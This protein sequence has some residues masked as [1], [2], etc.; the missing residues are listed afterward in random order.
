MTSQF[1][2]S[3]VRW[4]IFT[5]CVCAA[6]VLCMLVGVLVFVSSPAL[7]VGAGGEGGCPNE[8]FRQ[9]PSA[10][11]PDCRAYEMASPVYKG[12]YG[13]YG[14]EG[15]AQ[16]GESVAFYSPGAFAGAPAGLAEGVDTVAYM[17]RRSATGWSTVP[18]MPPDALS[19]T[20]IGAA[21]VSPTLD[22]EI[23]PVR[24]DNLEDPSLAQNR[25]EFG[26]HSTETPDLSANWEPFG[27]TMLEATVA[28]SPG[29]LVLEY[30][31]ASVD[32]CHIIFENPYANGSELPLQ[33]LLPAA[34]GAEQP[35]YELDRGCHGEPAE[36]RLVAV[37]NEGKALSPSCSPRLGVE[38]TGA[39]SAFNAVAGG[40]SE[41]FFTTCIDNLQ[42]DRQLFVRLGGGRT[43]E[44]SKP[45]EEA[46]AK[47]PCGGAA[48]RA[49]AVFAGADESGSKVFFTTTAPLS[50]EDKDSGNDLYMASIG[51]P[52]GSG[53]CE[54]TERVVTS[55]VQISH[56][57]VAG[58]PAEVQGV[59][60]VAPDGSRVY[61]V[62]RGVL[63][64][65]A[66]A[67]GTAP[68]KG[69]D[70]LYVYEQDALYP[71]GHIA[72]IGDLC[73][74]SEASGEAEDLRCP[75]KTGVDTALWEATPEAQTA[76]ADG[77]YLVFSTYAQ[78]LPGDADT[79]KDV[80]RY[81]AQ[82]GALARVSTGEAGYDANGNGA[83]N[84]TIAN[85]QSGGAVKQHYEMNSRAVSEDGSRIVFSTNEPLS[86]RAINGLENVYEW[87][88]ASAGSEG[89]VSLLS[90]GSAET[91]V[92]R[93]VISPGGNDVFFVTT[94]GLVPQD[95]DGAP[96]IYDARAD[97]GF[98]P[99][100]APRQQCSS[101]ACQGPLT[102]PAPLL[103]PGSVSQVPGGNFAA[104]A[105]A[106]VATVKSKPRS[107]P[108]KCKRGFV[109]KKGKCV[110]KPKAKKAGESGR[111][112]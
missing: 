35:L 81:D 94:Q 36:L 56:D 86:P 27:G 88:E 84:A 51:C 23:E 41:I 15:V 32:F 75:S 34:K 31:G 80:Y 60:R 17:T 37:N 87:H 96:D 78:L 101:D 20:S 100:A 105:A 18:L 40:G 19:K 33:A 8:A 99:A 43:L 112:K 74:G 76:G 26:L 59:M 77:R 9:G 69:A 91:A 25:M 67:Q 53:E 50:E 39:S 62:A 106:P 85:A 102:N 83:F 4:G 42:G 111:S 54:A 79:A 28:G 49:S 57:P 93:P 108:A 64:K 46:C 63:G 95:T 6:V 97:G 73:S 82:S 10:R 58:E 1:S 21:D 98:P 13:A 66:N 2:R 48:S 14:I 103:V 24:F 16:N 3:G 7:A 29:G 22:S 107:K 5:L 45:I 61:F 72:F 92:E 38:H 52:E 110:R 30:L 11:L 44:V 109:K 47:V 12:G 68:V 65:A 55:L 89:S 90:S 70:N 71:S 104:S